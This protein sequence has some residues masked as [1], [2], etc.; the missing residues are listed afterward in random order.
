MCHSHTL[1]CER[2]HCC[3]FSGGGSG[4]G[5]GGGGGQLKLKHVKNDGHNDFLRNTS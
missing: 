1:T 2:T 5:G 4:G 3:I